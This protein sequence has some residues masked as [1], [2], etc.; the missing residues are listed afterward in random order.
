MAQPDISQI[1][2]ALAQ[3]QPPATPQASATP[4]QPT[5]QPP[6]GYPPVGAIPAQ[7]PSAGPQQAAPFLP[8]PSSTGSFDLNAIKPVNSGSVSIADAIAKAKSIAA[9]RGVQSYDPRSSTPREDPRL[10]G[11]PYQGSRS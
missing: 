8:Q 1:L 10:A 2:A 6:P 11:R 4:A 9:D 7:P 3:Q 5:P